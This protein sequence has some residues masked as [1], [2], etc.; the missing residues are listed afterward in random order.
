MVIHGRPLIKLSLGP[1]HVELVRVGRWRPGVSRAERSVYAKAT[2]VLRQES[3]LMERNYK[4]KKSY[5]LG[6]EGGA[7]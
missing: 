5:E 3:N 7:W 4:V 2:L 6:G 1:G